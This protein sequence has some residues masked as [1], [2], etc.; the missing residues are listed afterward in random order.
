MRSKINRRFTT[1]LSMIFKN[2]KT[3][4]KY[5]F[6][7]FALTRRIR[8]NLFVDIVN[9]WMKLD[10]Q[11][12]G[13]GINNTGN[14]EKFHVLV[15]FLV[16]CRKVAFLFRRILPEGILSWRWMYCMYVIL[17]YQFFHSN[18]Y[19]V[20][21]DSQTAFREKWTLITWDYPYNYPPSTEFNSG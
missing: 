16:I 8:S 11:C 3:N 9:Y 4:E 20:I 13:T 1:V 12:C 18:S 2:E 21:T 10:K 15:R 14:H 6:E 19:R 7:I 17:S 5:E